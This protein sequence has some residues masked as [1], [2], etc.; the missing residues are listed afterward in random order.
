ML[1]SA[2]LIVGCNQKRTMINWILQN[3]DKYFNKEVIVAGQV[4]E[5]HGVNLYI[6]EAGAYQIDDGSGL[7]WVITKTGLPMQGDEVGLKGRV[8]GGVKLFGERFGVVIQEHERR[9]R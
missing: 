4:R 7:I 2:L 3:P 9:T 1:I 6:A 8:D 5:T